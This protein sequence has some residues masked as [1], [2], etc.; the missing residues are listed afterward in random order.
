MS[1]RSTREVFDD[2]LHLALIGD[3]ETDIHRNFAENCVLL[4][5]YGVFKGYD[6]IREAAELLMRQLPN[7][8]Y[9]YRTTLCHGEIAFVEWEADADG[10]TVDD[11]ADSFL[12][13]NGVIEVMTIHYTVREKP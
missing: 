5:T 4:T 7:A 11:G 2:H 9:R 8:Q 6:G 3:V 1:T 12:I 10:V 13:R